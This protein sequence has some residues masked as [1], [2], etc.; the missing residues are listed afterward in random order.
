MLDLKSDYFSD[1]EIVGLL[2]GGGE[3][4]CQTVEDFLHAL[5]SLYEISPDG[6][7]ISTFK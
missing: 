6:E 7:P 2:M 1:S 3:D 5:L 4:D